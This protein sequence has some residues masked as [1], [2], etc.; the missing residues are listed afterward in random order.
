MRKIVILG[1]V[2]AAYFIHGKVVFSETNLRNWVGQKSAQALSG[3]QKA[4]DNFTDDVEVMIKAHSM[5]KTW[6]VEGG[7]DELCGYLRQVTA[8]LTV[9]QAHVETSADNFKVQP[10]GFPWLDTKVSYTE[11]TTISAGQYFPTITSSSEEE[12]VIT[13]TLTG[14]KIKSITSTSTE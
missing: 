13:R 12:L 14:L 3:D 10:K 2:V 11:H 4:C 1:L 9:L 7:K 6:E 5:H 8:A